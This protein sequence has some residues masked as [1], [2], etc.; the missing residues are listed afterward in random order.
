MTR[1]SLKV[2]QTIVAL[3][4]RVNEKVTVCIKIDEFC[5]TMMNFVVNYDEFCIKNDE[6]CSKL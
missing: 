4:T 3:E 2:G 1:T 5:I 6:F